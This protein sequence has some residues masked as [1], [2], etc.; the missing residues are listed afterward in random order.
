MYGREKDKK[1]NGDTE[2]E[3]QDAEPTLNAPGEEGPKGF[4]APQDEDSEA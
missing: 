2:F 4:T 3:D 1:D